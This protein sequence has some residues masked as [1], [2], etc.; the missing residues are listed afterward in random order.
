MAD[1]DRIRFDHETKAPGI[2]SGLS[3]PRRQSTASSLRRKFT[4]DIE[5]SD[6][7]PVESEERDY[8]HRQVYIRAVNLG[9]L[10]TVL[11][12]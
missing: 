5:A 1:A 12:F 4:K 10:C 8:K 3:R 2:S 9:H 11:I 7:Q 6:Y